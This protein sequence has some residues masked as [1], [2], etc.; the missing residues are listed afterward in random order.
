[1]AKIRYNITYNGLAFA[2]ERGAPINGGSK[3]E[4]KRKLKRV[5]EE[6]PNLKAHKFSYTTISA[7]DFQGMKWPK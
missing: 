5:I 7:H 1:M 6:N 3:S 2:R 4:I